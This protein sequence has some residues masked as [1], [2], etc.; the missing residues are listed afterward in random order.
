MAYGFLRKYK[1]VHKNNTLYRYI[2]VYDTQIIG[3]IVGIIFLSREQIYK[4]TK[5]L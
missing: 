5:T 4:M 2:T 3:R 1:L